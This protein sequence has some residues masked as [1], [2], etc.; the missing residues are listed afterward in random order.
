MSTLGERIKFNRKRNGLN[1]EQLANAIGV[2][3]M[4]IRPVSYTHLDVY[5]RQRLY[6][7]T[8]LD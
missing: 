6:I 8:E 4:S 7:L 2:S 5:K 3:M 1:Q